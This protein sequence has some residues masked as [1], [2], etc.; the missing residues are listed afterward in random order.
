MAVRIETQSDGIAVVTVDNPPVNALSQAIRQGLLDAAVALDA[1]P[2]V[3]GVVL[4]CAGRTFIAGADISEFGKPPQAPRLPD[5]IARIERAAK[6]WLAAIHGAAL[7][8]GLEVALGCRWRVAEETARFGLPEVTLGI[9]PGAGGTVRLPRL[10]D[11]KEAIELAA[12]GRQ[13]GAAAARDIGLIDA[14]LGQN[15]RE[16][17]VAFL[18]DAL[19]KPWPTILC[20]RP[21]SE[22]PADFWDEQK[23]RIGKRARGEIA[24]LR[25]LESLRRATEQG[26]DE[27]MAFERRTFLDL[28]DSE[29]ARALRY[30]FFAER[31]AHKPPEYDDAAPRQ[32]ET[33]AVIGGGTM[34]AGIAA[35][36]RNAGLPVILVERDQAALERGLANVGAIFE[37]ATKRGGLTPEAAQARMAGVSGTTDY[38][39]LVDVDLVIEAVF[40]DIEVKRAVFRS[41]SGACRPDAVL[42]TNTSYLDPNAIAEA[43]TNPERMIGLHFF[44]PANVMKLLEIVPAA[45]TADE[46]VATGLALARRL[47]KIPVVAGI[48]D[49]FIGNRILKVTRAQAERLIL[50][51]ATPREV[52]GAMRSFG[53]PMGPFEAQDLGGLDIAAFQRK[54]ARARGETPFA[55]VA[56]RLVDMGRLGQK[57]GGGWYDY[58][59]G[60]RTPQPSPAVAAIV[61]DAAALSLSRQWSAAEIADAIVLPMINEA[62]KILG[63][64]IAKRAADIDLVKIHGYGFPRWRGGPMHYAEARGLEEVAAILERLSADGLAEPPGAFL[65]AAAKRGGFDLSQQ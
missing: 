34:G 51:G 45:E 1:D 32:I 37:A 20:D 43:V 38:A 54:A 49:G 22:A 8:G 28:R 46:I 33:S 35:A 64:G 17:A 61:A 60:D 2:R 21:A 27:A 58:S 4:L 19:S 48:C 29:Q 14:M 31:S 18:I 41:L 53:M 12:A 65:R 30:V 6:P 13:I 3:R 55:P 57:S 42:A 39:R 11:A 63:E 56:D 16:K 5:V 52:D 25:A 7:G 10:V 44:S 40:E 24:P 26:F 50:S 59:P 62:S 15:L 9:I 36:L 23:A 47:A